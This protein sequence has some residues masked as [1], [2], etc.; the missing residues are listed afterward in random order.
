MRIVG[1]LK[2]ISINKMKLSYALIVV[3]LLPVIHLMAVGPV[4]NSIDNAEQWVNLTNSVF[5]SGG[6]FS[7]SYGPLF[8]LTG[9]VAEHYNA[10][11]YYICIFLNLLFYSTLLWSVSVM[12][13]KG[14]GYILSLLVLLCFFSFSALRGILFL[15]PLVF[16]LHRE[17]IHEKKSCLTA[18]AGL[19]LGILVGLFFYIRFFYGLIA[20]LLI[21]GY[22]TYWFIK[23]WC[24]KSGAIFTFSMICSFI[25]IGLLIYGDLQSVVMYFKINSQLSYGNS[26]DMTLDIANYTR[27]FLCSFSILV[28]FIVYGVY[29]RAS[30]LIPLVLLWIVLFKLGYGRADHYII[31]FIIPCV[32]ICLLLSFDKGALIKVLSAISIAVLYYLGT[33][34]AYINAPKL[35]TFPSNVSLPALSNPFVLPFNKDLDYT[36]RMEIQYKDYKLN[37]SLLMLIGKDKIDIYP[38]NNEYAFSNK[39]NYAFRPSFQNYMT[40]TPELDRLNAQFYSSKDKPE[41]IIWNSGIMCTDSDCNSFSGMDNKLIVNED[42]LTNSAILKNYSFFQLFSGK[43]GEPLSLWKRRTLPGLTEH[44]LT[45]QKMQFER[46]YPVPDRQSNHNFIKVALDLKLTSFGRLKN[47]LFRGDI[48]K[49]RYKLHG[50]SVKEYRLNIINSLS[51]VWVSP[52]INGFDS[53]GFT[54]ENVE[55]IMFSIDS[56]YYL[57]PQFTAKFIEFSGAG[58]SFHPRAKKFSHRADINVSGNVLDAECAGSIDTI[59]EKLVSLH[60]KNSLNDL[61]VKGWLAKSTVDGVLFD[62]TFIT[63]TDAKNKRMYF[64]TRILGRNDLISVF[65]HSTLS[66]A[67]FESILPISELKGEYTLSLAG[68][69]NQQLIECRNLKIPVILN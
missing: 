66:K 57:E 67:G 48:L 24:F 16:L 56:D 9:G 31:Y 61:D 65:G 4:R 26:V 55:A 34:S 58:L 14:N 3:L 23:S 27:V 17:L 21:G 60:D 40:L 38:Y 69:S 2:L 12:M 11:T 18:V 43:N 52:L 1:L 64:D 44:L 13:R 45:T 28:F 46:W 33:Q 54:G 22:F 8:W 6:V 19:I 50:G 10:A 68:M 59:N 63:L 32:F 51:G 49:V 29:C 42:P 41:W 47:L 30:F 5:E 20:F 53:T 37:D 62:S 35:Q 25:L 36:K 7:F 39:L 15:W